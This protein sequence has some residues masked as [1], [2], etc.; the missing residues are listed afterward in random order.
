MTGNDDL[1]DGKRVSLLW[2]GPERAA[3]IARV[4]R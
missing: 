1:L 3:D 4:H 2:A